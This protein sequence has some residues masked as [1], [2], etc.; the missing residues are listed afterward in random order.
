MMRSPAT[1]R[2]LRLFEVNVRYDRREPG[3]YKY[4]VDVPALPGC[5]SE[6]RTRKEAVA[7]VREAIALMLAARSPR[8]RKDTEIVEI[9]A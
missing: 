7:N 2:R 6:G 3:P 5:F 9:P 8:M 4:T 1:P